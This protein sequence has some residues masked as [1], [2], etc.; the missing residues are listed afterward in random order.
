M[1]LLIDAD[2][3]VFASCCKSKNNKNDNPFYTDIKD[4]VAKFDE[5]YMKIVNDMQVHYDIEK[6][7][8]FNGCKGNFRKLITQNYKANRKKQTLPPL[9]HPMH[10]YVKDQYNSKF[11]FG[12]ETDDMVARYW[13][14]LTDEFGRDE[15][16]IVSIDKD[17]KQFPCIM[18]NYHPNTKKIL[19]I[20]EYEALYNFYEQCIVGDTADNVNYFH[21]KG[22]AF[23]K[24]YYKDCFTKYQFTKKLFLLFKEKYKSKAREKYIECFSLLKLRTQ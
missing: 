1:I 24:K 8:T 14:T 19:D 4:S 9:L 10:Q 13:K 12:I 3:L 16:M 17:Y 6:V 22:K 11:G 2:S 5:Q 20:S 15:V 7:I 18:Y 23:A 21:G